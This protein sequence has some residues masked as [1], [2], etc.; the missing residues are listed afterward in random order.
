MG[1]LNNFIGKKIRASSLT[2]VIVSTSI[3]LIVFAISIATLNNVMVSTVR[4][5]SQQLET[6]MERFVYQYKNNPIKI[7]LEIKEDDWVC[8]IIKTKYKGIDLLEFSI[9]NIV[10]Q[11]TII[12]NEIDFEK[13]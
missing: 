8:K 1:R 11:K 4:N 7:P 6:K 9:T 12:K 2:E 3:L 5:D 13:E 10:T